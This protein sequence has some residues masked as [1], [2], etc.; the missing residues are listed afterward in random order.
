MTLDTVKKAV[1]HAN[2]FETIFLGG[3]EPTLHR[4]LISIVEYLLSEGRR[5]NI[6]TNGSQVE[7]T[8]KLLDMTRTS[9]LFVILSLDKYH[10]D[11]TDDIK[12]LFAIPEPIDSVG[13]Y[14]VRVTP[15]TLVVKGGRSKKGFDGC[16]HKTHGLHVLPDGTW[17]YCDDYRHHKY[18]I[19]EDIPD[20]HV[21]SK[22]TY[23]YPRLW[24]PQPL[25]KDQEFD[26]S[27]LQ[28]YRELETLDIEDDYLIFGSAALVGWG[29]FAFNRDIDIK[30]SL[31][32]FDKLGTKYKVTTMHPFGRKSIRV[33]SLHI[34]A[35]SF[36]FASLDEELKCAQQVRSNQYVHKYN[37]VMN[38]TGKYKV[39]KE[40]FY[41]KD[42]DDNNE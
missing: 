21:C 10:D 39:F 33:G 30:V 25:Y 23:P 5:I 37:N 7:V 13:G 17:F 11:I 19:G 31:N 35:D 4:D 3:G 2:H 36:M 6:T 26:V 20:E 14:G 18:K 27:L 1:A 29:L 41:S 32:T 40:Y 28:G 42:N 8:K 16:P 22:P 38:Y 15:D 24:R 12:S 34:S 9:Q